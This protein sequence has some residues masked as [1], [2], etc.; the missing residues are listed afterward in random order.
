MDSYDKFVMQAT[1]I[2]GAIK[3]EFQ[4]DPDQKCESNLFPKHVSR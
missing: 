3:K 2:Y 1:E 4:M